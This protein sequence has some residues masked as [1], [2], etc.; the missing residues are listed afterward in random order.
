MKHLALVPLVLLFAAVAHAQEKA[1]LPQAITKTG[2]AH[3]QMLPPVPCAGLAMLQSVDLKWKPLL[4]KKY[5]PQATAGPNQKYLDS[6]KAE[7][8]IQKMATEASRK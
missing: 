5:T 6:L 8:L 2:E 7:K 1:I 4:T 3:A